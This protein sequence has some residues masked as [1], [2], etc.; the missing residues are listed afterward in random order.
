MHIDHVATRRV[1][2]L[3]PDLAPL[4]DV[5]DRLLNEFASHLSL[6][7]IVVTV[8]HCRSDLDTVP[9]PALPEL[10]ERLARQRLHDLARTGGHVRDGI[11]FTRGFIR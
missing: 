9:V 7:A 8:R 3:T 2:G 1:G 6:N 10:T 4:A 11:S 5:V